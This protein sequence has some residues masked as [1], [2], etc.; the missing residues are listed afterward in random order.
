MPRRLALHLGAFPKVHAVLVCLASS[1]AS[2]AAASEDAQNASTT[3]SFFGM[4]SM[5]TIATHRDNGTL[6]VFAAHAF[7][8]IAKLSLA[9]SFLLSCLAVVLAAVVVLISPEWRAAL[10]DTAGYLGSFLHYWV[11]KG[12]YNSS[13]FFKG[14]TRARVHLYSMAL[15][16]FL[17]NRPHYRSGTFQKDMI[18]NLRN[19]ALPGTGIPLS[20]L[21]YTRVTA[22]AFLLFGYP[23]ACLAYAVA[24]TLFP[25][26]STSPTQAR[27]HA[28]VAEAYRAYLLHPDDWFNFWRLNCRLAS[29]HALITKAPGFGMEDKFD[30]LVAADKAGVPVSPFLK[31]GGIVVKDRNEEGGMG[32]RFYRNAAAGGEWII[33]ETLCNSD[34]IAG[35]LPPNAPL[36]TM[37]VV[38][39]SRNAVD[40]IGGEMVEGPAARTE[41][42]D[43]LGTV[44]RAGRAGAATDHSSVLFDVDRRTGTIIKGTTNDHWYRLWGATLRNKRCSSAYQAHPDTGTMLVGQRFG[45]ME[46]IL[47][48][49]RRAHA[50]LL[51]D[52]PLGGWDVALTGND[53]GICLLEV[54]LS[55]NFFNAS[56]DRDAYFAFVDTCFAKLD[57]AKLAL[58]ASAPEATKNE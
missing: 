37:R 44:F 55:C 6:L 35:W 28:T 27:K 24:T 25:S 43:V 20:L 4:P 16:M 19:V 34:A 11:F 10:S 47:A 17:W 15:I 51:P 18:K 3:D 53:V 39:C 23:L 42:V 32:I 46:E 56:F 50:V 5:D 49:V 7:A 13:P 57:P 12:S 2:S 22:V 9:L 48:L 36:S 21:C 52:V 41:R 45:N 14:D 38:T 30:F 40:V 29:L 58:Q 54:N 1:L 26:P 8:T 33:Q 31:C